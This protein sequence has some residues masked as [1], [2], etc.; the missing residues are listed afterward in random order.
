MEKEMYIAHEVGTE[1]T[2]D[3]LNYVIS[4]FN[5]KADKYPRLT[6][7]NKHLCLHQKLTIIDEDTRSEKVNIIFEDVKYVFEIYDWHHELTPITLFRK[8]I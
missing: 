7:A 1:A 5:L 2:I 3:N 6:I 4:G 8:S